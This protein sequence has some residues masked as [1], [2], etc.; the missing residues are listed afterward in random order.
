MDGNGRYYHHGNQY[1][2]RRQN[3]ILSKKKLRDIGLKDA[4]LST[5]PFTS[6]PATHNCNHSRK[7][8]EGIFTSLNAEVTCAGFSSF[9]S[10]YPAAPS[11]GHRLIWAEL[12]NFS[13]LGKHIPFYNQTIVLMVPLT[14][15]KKS[16]SQNI[17]KSSTVSIFLSEKPKQQLQ[18]N[19]K[20][21]FWWSTMISLIQKTR[22]NNQILEPN[23]QSEEEYQH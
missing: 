1:E 6:P 22:Q 10:N 2:C 3:F 14:L 7:V 11:Y 12:D 16:L 19:W 18:K 15:Q 9:D 17:K 5:H 21:I 8:I 20:D 23:C 13:I 4:V